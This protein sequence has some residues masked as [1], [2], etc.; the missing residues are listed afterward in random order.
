[1]YVIFDIK[2]ALLTYLEVYLWSLDSV[3]VP[4]LIILSFENDLQT[5]SRLKHH[6]ERSPE[7]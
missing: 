7:A 2:P 5:S 3:P 6:Y 1:M 4:R